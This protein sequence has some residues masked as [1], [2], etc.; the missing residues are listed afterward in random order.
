MVCSYLHFSAEQ[1]EAGYLNSK[2]DQNS[3]A[4]AVPVP[5]WQGGTT[6]FLVGISGDNNRRFT[7]TLLVLNLALNT[8]MEPSRLSH[9]GEL[10]EMQASSKTSLSANIIMEHLLYTGHSA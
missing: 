9:Q 2:K 6:A 3:L 7:E 1:I 4:K 8:Y 5:S 10:P